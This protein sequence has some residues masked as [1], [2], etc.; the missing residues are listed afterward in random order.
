MNVCK[1]HHVKRRAIRTEKPSG[2]TSLVEGVVTFGPRR[3]SS[4]RRKVG[5]RQLSGGQFS[6][7]SCVLRAEE[8]TDFT[9]TLGTTQRC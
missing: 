4:R 8:G 5:G 1:F 7:R 6:G 2:S 3:D 9:V